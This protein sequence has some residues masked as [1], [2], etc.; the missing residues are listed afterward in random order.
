MLIKHNL[1]TAD[2]Y[3]YVRG[4]RPKVECILCSVRDYDKKVDNLLIYETKRLMVTLNLYPYN[5]GH[6]MIFPKRHIED[7]RELQKIEWLEFYDLQNLCLNILEHVYNPTGFNM[8]F[9]MGKHG[10]ASIPHIHFHIVP[11]Y[12][13]EIGFLE[14][15]SD[16]RII[17]E[18]PETTLN[19]LKKYFSKKNIKKFSKK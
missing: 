1:I 15:V 6:L 8:G 12:Q 18:K 10:G 16:G 2:K 9:N 17:V 19:K 7:V 5:P 11:R 4:I 3:D 14:L 13:N